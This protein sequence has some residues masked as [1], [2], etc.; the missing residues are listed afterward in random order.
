MLAGWSNVKDKSFSALP[1]EVHANAEPHPTT[2]N[3]S[4]RS[5]LLSNTAVL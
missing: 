2:L 1:T 4:K 5:V 3:A